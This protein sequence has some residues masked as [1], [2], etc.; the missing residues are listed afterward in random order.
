MIAA[1]VTLA[2]CAGSLPLPGDDV[3]AMSMIMSSLAMP[4]QEK[5]VF[6]E[7]RQSPL[8]DEIVTVS[9]FLERLDDDT[10]V[11]VIEEPVPRRLSLGRELVTVESTGRARETAI[12]RYPALAGLRSG[13]LG[14]ID[15]DAGALLR[16]FRPSVETAEDGW[17]LELVPRQARI[18][19]QLNRLVVHGCDETLIAVEVWLADGTVE[20]M[21]F[22][23]PVSSGIE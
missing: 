5:L 2:A 1:L 22:V 21:R 8:F 10:L 3:D 13:L 19:R 14:L 16:V 18:E 6:V 20:Q 12:S 17:W 4:G 11:K 9:G 7:E 23:T 15:R